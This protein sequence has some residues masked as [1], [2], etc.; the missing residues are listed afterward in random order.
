[1]RA[2]LLRTFNE[3]YI[4]N[5]HGNS[6]KQEKTPDGSKDENI[7]DIMVGVSI[8]IGIKTDNNNEWAKVKYAELFG[9]RE[10]K[11]SKLESKEIEF[12]EINIDKK[13][14]FFIPQINEEIKSEY[15]NG[16]S[17]VDLFKIYS[18]GIVT[19]RDGLCI[20]KTKKDIE[21]ILLDFQVDTAEN[22]KN[23]YLLGRDTD[24]TINGAQKDI[25]ANN[26]ITTKIA[27]RIFD[28][29]WTFY[30]GKQNGFYCRSR[31][32]V[33]NN[34]I[35]QDNNIGFIFARGDNSSKNFSNILVTNKIT[36]AHITAAPNIATV[37][38]LFIK[39]NGIITEDKPN[40][41]R[42]N[43]TKLTANLETKPSP[44]KVFD[45]CYGILND[46]QYRKKYNEFLKRDYPRVPII[47]N[48][49]MFDRY[50]NAGS[51]L[52]KLHLMQTDAT[53]DLKIESENNNLLIEQIKY[54]NGKLYINKQTKILG[55]TDDIWDFYLGGYQIIDK[56]LK[57]HKGEILSMEYFTH[58]KKIAGIIEETI[59][60]QSSL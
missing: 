17:L 51:L 50:V 9:L 53:K 41:S 49:K 26:G 8:I 32:E 13:M 59:R 27:Y 39:A 58:I 35:G 24:W 47:E 12:N 1:M 5:L 40:F 22:I 36:D 2:S 45:Y 56:W 28:D 48:E 4:L 54:T 10:N 57:S 6:I 38:P 14:A 7:F 30:S 25:N 52:R 11:L 46:L 55:I 16:V 20:Q 3:I 29:R 18:A 19:G 21:N 23:K 42:E 31:G 34:F 37:V 60:I 15:D 43:L 44:Q 33:M